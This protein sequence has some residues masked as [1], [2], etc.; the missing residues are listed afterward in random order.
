MIRLFFSALFFVGIWVEVSGQEIMG[1]ERRKATIR[2]A[3]YTTTVDDS[4]SLTAASVYLGDDGSFM[5]RLVYN[6][7]WNGIGYYTLACGNYYSDD[8]K[9]ELFDSLS[10]SK[11]EFTINDNR[12]VPLRAHYFMM[13]RVF[14][15]DLPDYMKAEKY[16]NKP[17]A[18]RRNQITGFESALKE[19]Q[20]YSVLSSPALRKNWFWLC[21]NKGSYALSFGSSILSKGVYEVSG[22]IIVLK[23]STLGFVSTLKFANSGGDRLDILNF[24]L[25]SPFLAFTLQ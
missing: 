20:V 18:G 16:G 23:D 25:V 22:D 1:P 5:I 2:Y 9:L 8:G 10:N 6:N 13:D 24:P 12:L 3:V 7:S 21:F 15:K 14:I 4:I 19:D 17:C 11:L